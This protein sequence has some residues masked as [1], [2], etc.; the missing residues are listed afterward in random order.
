MKRLGLLLGED[1]QAQLPFGIG[2]GLDRLPQI[3]AME[4]GVGAGDLDGLVP[5]QRM[6]AGVRVPVE[7]D[8]ARLALRR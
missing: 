6:R 1:L 4:V 5:D 7:L 3:A 2:A 8:E